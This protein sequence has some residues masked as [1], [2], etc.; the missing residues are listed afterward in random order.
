M[1]LQNFLKNSHQ[2][3]LLF[4]FDGN[5]ETRR[6]DAIK[7]FDEVKLCKGYNYIDLGDQINQIDQLYKQVEFFVYCFILIV[8]II[9]VVNIF[10]TI[11]TNLIL[12]RKNFNA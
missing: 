12:R 9:S 2:N 11:S 8:T 4:N 7:Y 3:S 6:A 1:L 10:N 5:D